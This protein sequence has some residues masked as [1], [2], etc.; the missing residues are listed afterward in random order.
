MEMRLVQGGRGVVPG[1]SC[2]MRPGA[3]LWAAVRGGPRREA[4]SWQSGQC[5]AA[6]VDLSGG[7]FDAFFGQE[8]LLDRQSAGETGE[9]AVAANHAVTR[10]R[11]SVGVTV[12]RA[13]N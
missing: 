5:E 11:G 3:A 2:S 1:L 13:A 10:H 8:L 7:D 12:Q 9:R 6:Q 4:G